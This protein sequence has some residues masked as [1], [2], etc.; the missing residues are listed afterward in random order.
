MQKDH[1]RGCGEHS[2]A[3]DDALV[4]DGSSPRMRGALIRDRQGHHRRRII[5]ADAGSTFTSVSIRNSNW[6]HPRG[7]GEHQR[8]DYQTWWL[9][10]S[11]PRMRG[12][13]LMLVYHCLSPGIIP[14][15]AGSTQAYALQ[16]DFTQDHPR[17]CGEHLPSNL[18]NRMKAGSSPRMRGALAFYPVRPVSTG[19]IPADA[20]STSRQGEHTQGKG[21]HPRGC[22]EHSRGSSFLKENTGSSP[23]MRGAHWFK[24]CWIIVV[25]IIPA[26][27]GSTG[28]LPGP[29]CESVDHPRGCG[30]HTSLWHSSRHRPG[31]SP[32]MRG[33]RGYIFQVSGDGGIIP[34]D[35]GSTDQLGNL[36]L[37]V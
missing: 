37:D 3:A 20:G 34:A 22:G 17:G 13:P 8:S 6:D 16:P 12:A 14:A 28:P 36:P 21:D 15:D 35:A 2:H 24:F 26:D 23:R 29:P 32:R 18:I 25:R 30:E 7:C 4:L 11:S 10:G 1:P 19:I 31:S 5:P 9:V 27:A 33:A